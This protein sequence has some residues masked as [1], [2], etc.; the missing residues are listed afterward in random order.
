MPVK[1]RCRG[2]EKVLSAPDKARGKVI[3]CPQCGTKLKVPEGDAAAKAPKPAKMK[4]KAPAMQDS[5]EFLARVDLSN[6]ES[7]EEK[8]CPY[9]AAEMDEEQVVCRKCGMNIETGAMD[10]REAK[11]RARKGPDPALFYKK[12]WSDSFQFVKEHWRMALQSGWYMA[13]LAVLCSGCAAMAQWCDRGPPIFFWSMLTFLTFLGI[14]GWFWYQ[15]YKVI[16]STMTKDDK[17]LER[18]H[19][20]FFQVIALGIR[21]ILWPF[22]VQLPALPIL[23]GLSIVL[24]VAAGIAS[25]SPAVAALPALLLFGPGLLFC[26]LMYP[27]ATVHLTQK[28]TYKA[29]IAWELLKISVRNLG[30]ALYYFVIAFVTVLPVAAIVGIPL[31]LVMQHTNPFLS[32]NVN[33]VTGGITGWLL[34]MFGEQPE[35][36]GWLFLAIKAP[37]NF[38]AAFITIVPFW[39]AIAFP[40]VF[41]MRVNGLL[42]HYNRERLG[43]VNHINPDTPANFWVRVLAYCVDMCLWPF[44]SILVVKEPK[45]VIVAWLINAVMLISLFF[46]PIVLPF[47]FWVWPMYNY[48]MYFAV[49]E[50]TTTRTTIGKDAFGLIVNDLNGKQLTLGKATLRVFGRVACNVTAGL[51]YLIAAFHPQKR[52]LHDLIAGTQCCWRGDR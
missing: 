31:V 18:V 24:G 8:I 42:G 15:T 43:L 45:A 51:G 6:L 16:E 29:W 32:G 38:I 37:L 47:L 9:C 10:A 4:S 52:G 26:G 7:E 50:H 25:E 14:C 44:A 13:F 23:G 17:I 41:M 30:P 1:I 40:A 48:W 39:L 5:S 33:W 27:I 2:C 28:Y 21:L 19:F 34:R 46:V 3:Q 11:K 12:A 36:D 35:P 22:V 20:D 49:S